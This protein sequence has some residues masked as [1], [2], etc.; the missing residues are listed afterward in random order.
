M[1]IIRYELEADQV[2][3]IGEAEIEI[4]RRGEKYVKVVIDA[5]KDVLI[6]KPYKRKKPTD[7]SIGVEN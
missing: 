6:I 5:P 3:K 2:I 4:K 7:A 1:L